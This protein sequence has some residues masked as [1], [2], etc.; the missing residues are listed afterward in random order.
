MTNP[1][2][3]PLQNQT[4]QRLQALSTGQG[5]TTATLRDQVDTDHNGEISTTEAQSA[6]FAA[7][8]TGAINEAYHSHVSEPSAVVFSTGN[9]QFQ[10]IFRRV[11]ANNDGFMS[12]TELN[13]AVHSSNFRGHDAALVAALYKKVSDVEEYSDDEWGDEND[14]IT[15]NDLRTME[16]A[17]DETSRRVMGLVS[18]GEGKISSTNR[19]LF[20]NGVNS[21]RPDNI[22]Q[23]MVG[24]CFFIASIAARANTAE[25]RQAIHDMIQDN[26]NG[27]YTVNFPGR[28]EV[29]VDAPTDGELALYSGSG[30]DG[31]WMAVLE[32]AYAHSLNNA[33]WV[34]AEDPYDKTAGGLATSG[35]DV[36]SSRGSDLDLLATSS[37]A[38][39]RTKLTE[40][41]S[42]G[43]MVVAGVRN[44]M[45]WTSGR[46]DNGLPMGHA[47]SVL[48][49]D[50]ATDTVT[51]R[52][53][54]GHAEPRNASG[55]AADGTDDGVFTMTLEEFNQNFTTIGYEQ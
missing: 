38:E 10:S 45:P 15:L 19:Q 22:R 44:A 47:Y 4:V 8:D 6:G 49:F 33:A 5:V 29:T 7:E 11:D 42:N 36:M 35:I 1:I 52:N 26:H 13:T 2:S 48:A 30:S 21:I 18:Y 27:T 9:L 24:D 51:L 40:A 32:K 12:S 39:Q 31:L 25:G 34:S 3:Q 16:S 14:G 54:W 50:A 37:Y 53:P 41:L 43:R 20:P 28:G 17:N 55:G 23:G 46:R